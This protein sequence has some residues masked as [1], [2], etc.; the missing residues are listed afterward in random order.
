MEQITETISKEDK[1]REYMRAYM[2]QYKA[3]KYAEDAESIRRGNRTRYAKKTKEHID[4]NDKQRYGNHLADVIA[5][6][7]LIAR[8]PQQYVID[9]F[10][11][12]PQVA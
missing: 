8:I 11:Q 1:K 10:P 7:D 5:L 6:R 2:K 3:K 9:L 12:P 4:A